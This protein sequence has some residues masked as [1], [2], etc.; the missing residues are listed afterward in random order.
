MTVIKTNNILQVIEQQ[1][2][3]AIKFNLEVT[4]D[5]PLPRSTNIKQIRWAGTDHPHALFVEFFGYKD[6]EKTSGYIYQTND[7]ELW[8]ALL[9]GVEAD[10]ISEDRTS[11]GRVF[12]QQVKAAKIPYERVY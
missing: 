9:N 6:K 2:P 4:G 12:H 10:D 1:Y 7:W 3:S 11:T 8:K 5:E